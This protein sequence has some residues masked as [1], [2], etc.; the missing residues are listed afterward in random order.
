MWL[1]WFIILLQHAASLGNSGSSWSIIYLKHAPSFGDSGSSYIC[2]YTYAYTYKYT[3]FR[4]FV[5]AE[6]STQPN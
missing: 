1:Y 3:Y 5:L 4:I 2:L 6:V